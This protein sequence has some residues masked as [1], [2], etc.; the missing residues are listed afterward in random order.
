MTRREWIPLL[1]GAVG[2]AAA[3]AAACGSGGPASPATP[4]LSV[5]GDYSIQKTVLSDACGGTEGGFTN[6]GSV[7]HTP[8]AVSFVLNDHGTRD[9]PGSVA[10]DGTFTLLPFQGAAGGVPGRDTYDGGRF[11]A[12]GFSLAVRTVVFRTQGTPAAPDCVVTMRWHATKQG[13][14]NVIP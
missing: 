13:A 11:S 14:P 10:A 5:G 3:S 2:I 4:L 6:P 7:R 9:L 8:G 1:R 12:T